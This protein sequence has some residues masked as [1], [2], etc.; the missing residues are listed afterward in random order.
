MKVGAGVPVPITV[1]EPFVPTVNVVLSA[2]VI[3]G[4]WPTANDCWTWGAGAKLALPAW[5]AL[6]THVPTAV[7]ETV[8]PATEHTALADASIVNVTASPEVAV[9]ATA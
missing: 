6:I 2:L 4:S 9:A 7:N 1:N 3:A 5:L 8:E